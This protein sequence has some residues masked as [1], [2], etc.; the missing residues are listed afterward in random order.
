MDL[1]RAL[2]AVQIKDIPS[3]GMGASAMLRRCRGVGPWLMILILAGC[4]RTTSRDLDLGGNRYMVTAGGNG[5]TSVASVEELFAQRAREVAQLHGFDS[6]R[7]VQFGSGFES[8]P[9]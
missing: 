8:T 6:Y 3:V 2:V 1:T 4:T 7:I 5:Y 9:F